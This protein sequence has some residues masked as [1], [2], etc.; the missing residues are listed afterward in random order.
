M[1][2]IDETAVLLLQLEES[3]RGRWLSDPLRSKLPGRSCR[4]R[5][6]VRLRGAAGASDDLPEEAVQRR[7]PRLRFLPG[8]EI[9]HS[10]TKLANFA[11]YKKNC[12]KRLLEKIAG[13]KKR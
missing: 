5:E 12:W 1:K 6:S 4:L 3:A 13:K 7:E 9:I 8:G 11:I 2:P 10:A